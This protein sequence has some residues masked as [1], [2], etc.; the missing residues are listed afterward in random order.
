MLPHSTI[1]TRKTDIDAAA[2]RQLKR[3]TIDRG[4]ACSRPA[5]EEVQT[6]MLH[7]SESILLA[8][9][10]QQTWMLIQSTSSVY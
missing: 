6:Q 5:I 3:T 8:I 10:E 9:D 2:I 7:A 1:N 4:A